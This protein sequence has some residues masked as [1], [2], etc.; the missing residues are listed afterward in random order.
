MTLEATARA[1]FDQ[2]DCLL[3]KSR[4]YLNF[5]G[6]IG[7]YGSGKMD[8]MLGGNSQAHEP[9]PPTLKRVGAFNIPA[10]KIMSLT[11]HTPRSR[12]SFLLCPN[13]P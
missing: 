5:F 13:S 1:K 6:R 12:Q 10:R 4:T 11:C 9:H 2:D 3:A 8:F 7:L